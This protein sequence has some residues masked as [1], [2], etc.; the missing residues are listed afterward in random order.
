MRAA[1][2]LFSLAAGIG[3]F[4]PA[5]EVT[6]ENG[7]RAPLGSVSVGDRVRSW[8]F[9][10]ETTTGQAVAGVWWSR[11]DLYRVAVGSQSVLATADHPFWSESQQALV[12]L[13]PEIT[14]DRY[15]FEVVEL[16][17]NG[18]FFLG[19]DGSK[20]PFL[21]ATLEA[22]DARVVTL[23][24]REHHWFFAGGVLVHN[25]GGGGGGGGS[26]GT[27]GSSDGE[28][29]P[30]WVIALAVPAQLGLCYWWYWGWKKRKTQWSEVLHEVEQWSPG[31][32]PLPTGVPATETTWTGQYQEKGT[33]LECTMQLTFSDGVI[34]GT[35]KDKDGQFKVAGKYNLVTKEARFTETRGGLQAVVT[36]SLDMPAGQPVT[37]VGSYRSNTDY[38]GQMK[39]ACSHTPKIS[40]VPIVAVAIAP[41]MEQ[42][43]AAPVATVLGVV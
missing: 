41:E 19:F 37:F 38:N 9:E 36:G 7:S 17:R 28:A 11:G 29:P 34:T 24:V 8:D 14:K 39:L 25:K 16:M 33:W 1:V 2:L 43:P 30:I 6:L 20:V 12:S 23:T 22:P 5:T 3:C 26:S 32:Q 40:E 13:R 4:D 42:A 10:L 18:T 21:G 31:P 15:G 35:S 27:S